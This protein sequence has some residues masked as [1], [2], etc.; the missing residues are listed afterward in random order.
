MTP[1]EARHQL[2]V[3]LGTALPDWNIHPAPVI[4][5]PKP[6]AVVIAPRATYMT[7][8]TTCTWELRL[9][10]TLAVGI[11]S[12]EDGM[13]LMDDTLDVVVQ[14]LLTSAVVTVVD[15][16]STLGTAQDAGGV[17]YLTGT[18]NVTSYI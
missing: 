18:I 17:S 13:D 10:V 9:T 5:P 6:P 2:A 12:G 3:D 15:D 4:N 16:I 1:R 7:R 8:G 11:G 14:A